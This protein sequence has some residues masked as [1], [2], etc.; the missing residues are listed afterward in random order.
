MVAW[1]LAGCGRYAFDARTDAAAGS[2]DAHSDAS[3]PCSRFAVCDGFEGAGFDPIWQTG[4]NVSIDSTHVHRGAQAAHTH[5]DALTTG[6]EGYSMFGE[7]E[8]LSASQEPTT[9]YVR[10]WYYLSALPAGTNR[11]E[12]IAIEPIASNPTADY[13]FIHP[14]AVVL[15]TQSDDRSRMGAVAAPVNTWFCLD[16][17]VTR[18]TGNAGELALTSDAVPSITLGN[19]KTDSTTTP[20]KFVFFGIGCAATNVDNAQPAVDAWID[21]VI[22]DP[23]PVTCDD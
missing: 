4:A 13:T 1:A 21:D 16:M 23:A 12:A 6:M 19:A 17:K 8:T 22:V 5:V 2:G 10:A 15:Y 18:D 9:F 7:L 14:D 11:M 20:I 3:D